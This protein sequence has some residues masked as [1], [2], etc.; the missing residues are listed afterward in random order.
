M[1]LMEP[2]HGRS[3]RDAERTKEIPDRA[4]PSDA[5]AFLAVMLRDGGQDFCGELVRTFLEETPGRIRRIG[6]CLA[7]GDARMALE[8]TESLRIHSLDLDARPLARA[9]G[10]LEAHPAEAEGILRDIAM[11][12][13][14]LRPELEAFLSG[15]GRR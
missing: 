4:G 1:A 2:V 8:V 3:A 9:C 7:S 13:D 5:L 6:D 11:A 12:F 10:E 14:R 15:L